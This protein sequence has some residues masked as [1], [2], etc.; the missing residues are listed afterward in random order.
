MERELAREE[1][2]WIGIR[3]ERTE[4]GKDGG[5][6]KELNGRRMNRSG[7]SGKG[8]DWK[9]K[10]QKVRSKR[11]KYDIQ[12]HNEILIPGRKCSLFKVDFRVY[13]STLKRRDTSPSPKNQL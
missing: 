7:I 6:E 8:R 12:P 10:K 9:K 2:V 4:R 3:T 1:D 5:F 11:R 13:E